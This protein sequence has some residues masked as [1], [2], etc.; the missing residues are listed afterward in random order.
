MKQRYLAIFEKTPNNFG[1]FAPDVPGCGATGKTLEETRKLLSEGLVYHFE[2]ML[3]DGLPIPAP[4][5]PI[6]Y[7][8]SE[9]TPENGVE[10][11]V[12]EWLEVNV[13]VGKTTEVATPQEV[14]V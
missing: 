13:P 2:G 8:F 12:V 1:G 14:R 11:C 9:E 6:T 10:Y 7:D 3:E 4:T 5:V